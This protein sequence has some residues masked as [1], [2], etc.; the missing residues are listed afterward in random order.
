M[1][2]CVRLSN[3]GYERDGLHEVLVERDQA[4][5]DLLAA[6]EERRERQGFVAPAE[7]RAFLAATNEGRAALFRAHLRATADQEPP[8]DVA[9]SSTRAGT[10]DAERDGD[11]D[12]DLDEAAPRA[13][14]G[15][16]TDEPVRLERLRTQLDFA[17]EQDGPAFAMRLQELGYLANVL[18][19]A[20]TIQGRALTPAEGTTAAAS[21]C[22]L[23][24]GRVV[25]QTDRLLLDH[26]LLEVFA[27]GWASVRERVCLRAS[28]RLVDVLGRVRYHD[29]DTQKA[30]TA[31]RQDLRRHLRDRMPWRAAGALDVIAILDTPAWAALVGLIAECPVVHAAIPAIC[32]RR[33]TAIDPVAFEFFADDA[34]LAMVDRFLERLPEILTG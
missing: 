19:S 27:I 9:D 10:D 7:A 23:A 26:D 15:G 32:E 4:M 16:E 31:L 11:D 6:R 5:F 18:V 2:A 17:R 25:K 29:P 33:R 13:L 34:Q 1:R 24:I 21:L 3:D 8:S 14:L 20:C 28:K 30:L 22:N 12:L